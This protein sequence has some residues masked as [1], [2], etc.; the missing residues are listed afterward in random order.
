MQPITEQEYQ[1]ARAAIISVTIGRVACVVLA[2]HC[3]LNA[4]WTGAGMFLL[5]VPLL[6]FGLPVTK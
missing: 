4:E 5:G 2:I 3:A 6:H 1:R